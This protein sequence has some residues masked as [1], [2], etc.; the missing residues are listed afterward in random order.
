MV[1]VRRSKTPLLVRRH[2][3]DIDREI[4]RKERL[5]G[6][7]RDVL[8]ALSETEHAVP[9]TQVLGVLEGM[10]MLDRYLTPEQMTRLRSRR[11]ELG[12][13]PDRQRSDLMTEIEAA[14]QSGVDPRTESVQ[15][16]A[17]RLREVFLEFVGDGAT[18]AAL[19]TMV[20]AEG[21]ELATRGI[22]GPEF[23]AYLQRALEGDAVREVH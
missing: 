17:R 15:A 21:A 20:Q 7:L 6:R 18:A 16:A 10:T 12:P 2:L 8:A 19:A 14:R 3:D 13:E 4:V 22:V 1:S 23:A 9:I 5:R 11:A